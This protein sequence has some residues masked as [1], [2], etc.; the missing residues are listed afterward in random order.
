M[1]NQSQDPGILPLT[2]F[3][4]VATLDQNLPDWTLAQIE[5]SESPK[6]RSFEY[7]IRFDYPFSNVPLVHTGITGFDI[8]NGDTNRL[9]IYTENISSDGFNLVVQTWMYTRIY[10]V[11]VSWIALGNA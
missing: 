5:A 10:K 11:D 2:M 7:Y 3:S 1:N 6:P 9:R 4:S 8:D